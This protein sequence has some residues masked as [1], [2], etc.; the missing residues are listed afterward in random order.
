MILFGVMKLKALSILL[1]AAWL[2]M[3]YQLLKFTSYLQ[4]T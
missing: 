2:L 3:D 4:M 1:I